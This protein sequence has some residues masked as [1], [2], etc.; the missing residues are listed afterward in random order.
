M[1]TTFFTLS[2]ILAGV[3]AEANLLLTNPKTGQPFLPETSNSIG[4]NSNTITVTTSSA[5]PA[6]PT[7]NAASNIVQ[8]LFDA[9]WT[10]SSDATSYYLDVASDAGFTSFVTDYNN[11]N[12]GNVSTYNVSGLLCNTPYYYR[13]RAS[14]ACGTSINSNTITVTTTSVAPTVP[15]AKAAST[16]TQSSFSANWSASSAASKYYLDVSTNVSFISF[17]TGYNNLDVSNDTTYNVS[18]LV[19]NSTYYYRVRASNPYGTSSNS[20]T[21]SATVTCAT[22]PYCTINSVCSGN[23]TDSRDGKIYATVQI[24]NQCWMAGNLNVGT[25]IDGVTE[26]TSGSDNQNTS[27]QKY[28]YGNDTVNC[29]IYGGF[30]Q[31]DE[32]MAYGTSVSTNG[33]GPQGICPAGW[34]IPTDNEW[35]C[36]EM[37][38]GMLQTEADKTALLGT[39]EGGKLK[40]TGTTYWTSPNTGATNS[41]GFTALPGGY[42]YSL[43]S[44]H[45][46]GDF[47]CFWFATEASDANAWNRCLYYNGAQV[48]RYNVSKKVGYT[49][50]CVKD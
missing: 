6:D 14:N 42:R 15:S 7:A 13:I 45:G 33:P 48:V 32:M 26:Q 24:G 38:L 31:W 16:I 50:R 23:L 11:V 2:L 22:T 49:V 4:G 34:H 37:N 21:I 41:S 12:V 19:C 44:F 27:I 30:Y 8:A 25:R 18:G 40:K 47:G 1:K 43:G 17:V 9:N 46:V 10:T 35:K 36:L 39:D 20:S 28:C 3:L 5:T 29:N